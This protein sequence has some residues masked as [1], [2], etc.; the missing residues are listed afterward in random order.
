MTQTELL[1]TFGTACIRACRVVMRDDGFFKLALGLPATD[2]VI[3]YLG[4][5]KTLTKEGKELLDYLNDL[6]APSAD[7]IKQ[8][9]IDPTDER[10]LIEI[11][12]HW[13]SNP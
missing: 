9:E 1:D 8:P 5:M 2:L 11:Q 7:K 12:E 6:K 13:D 4:Q 10:E 3:L